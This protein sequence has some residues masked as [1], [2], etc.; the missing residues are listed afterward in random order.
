MVSYGMVSIP[1]LPMTNKPLTNGYKRGITST[2]A[3]AL[4]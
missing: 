3:G 2:S 1:D 4:S